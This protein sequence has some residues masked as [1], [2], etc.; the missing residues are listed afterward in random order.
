MI[1]LKRMAGQLLQSYSQKYTSVRIMSQ[2]KTGKG[3]PDKIVCSK[4]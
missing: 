3:L 4:N 2:A 1:V